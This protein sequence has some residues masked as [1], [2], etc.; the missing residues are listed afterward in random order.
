MATIIERGP[1]QFRAQIRRKGVSLS[2]TCES[3]REAEDWARVAEGKVTGGEVI[4]RKA[5]AS[6]GEACAWMLDHIGDRPNARNLRV[7]LGYWERSEF[8]SWSLSAIHSWDLVLWR[9]KVLA[10][11]ECGAQTI[12][13]RMNALSKLVQTWSEAHKI[14][15]ENPVK[16]KVRPGKPDGRNRR[17]HDGEEWLLLNAARHSSRQ[18]LRPA[19]VIALE[20]AMRQG[21]L[22]ALTWDRVRLEGP[23]PHIDLLKTKNDRPRTI[24]LSRRAIAALRVLKGGS[25]V[26]PV[27]TTQGIL[28]A[29][30]DAAER[31]HNLHWHDLRHESIGRFF[32][33]TDLRDM[34]I[35]AITG[36]LSTSMLLRYTHLRAGTLSDRL[37]GGAKNIR[38]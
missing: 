28:W 1:S 32:E 5:V 20:T 14:S 11:G 24:P 8:A 22:A 21:E 26:I 35:M 19:I 29:F 36:H 13:H 34:E 9:N 6:L 12:I 30:R 27:Q 33:R 38:P 16:R 25:K 37:P 17:L 7:K 2:H 23:H 18:W 15:L 3:R 4:E 31:F 10:S